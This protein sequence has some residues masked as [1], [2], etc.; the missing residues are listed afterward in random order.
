MLTLSVLPNLIQLKPF[1]PVLVLLIRAFIFHWRYCPN[2]ILRPALLC[3]PL[4]HISTAFST[5]FS[6]DFPTV[7]TLVK[8]PSFVG[9][10]LFANIHCPL[11]AHPAADGHVYAKLEYR[12]ASLILCHPFNFGKFASL[13]FHCR[14]PLG[15]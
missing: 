13:D 12:A 2:P 8:D 1:L 6:L 11:T 4:P 9:V 15:D 5:Q 14:T 7:R 3:R 10:H